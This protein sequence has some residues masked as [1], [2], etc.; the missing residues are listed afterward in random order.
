[1]LFSMLRLSGVLLC[2]IAAGGC[3]SDNSNTSSDSTNAPDAPTMDA[4]SEIEARFVSSTATMANGSGEILVDTKTGLTWINGGALDSRGDGCVSPANA[5]P[6]ELAQVNDR[7]VA[8]QYAGFDDWRAP[9]AAELSDLIKSADAD[10]SVSLKY[11]NPACPALVASDGFVRTENDNPSAASVQPGAATGDIFAAA[12][13]STIVVLADLGLP[14]GVRCVRSGT[15]TEPKVSTGSTRF[16]ALMG[17]SGGQT[18]VDSQTAL[19]WINDSQLDSNGDGCVSPANVG[20]T[21]PAEAESRCDNQN[22][23]G[24]SDWRAPTAAELT[25]L[26]TAA[27]ADGVKLNYLNPMC[28]ALVGSDGIVRTENANSAAE[29]AFPD[30]TTGAVLA[31]TVSGLNG[32]NAGVRCVRARN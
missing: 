21:E 16:S 9:S 2:V 1:M 4:G 8:Q 11:L 22:F 19:E 29:S 20:A 18:L 7:C 5:G 26:M 15:E 3:S 17:T 32:I 14:A 31:T 27:E 25:E 6:T 23:A 10:A 13:G 12:D 30:A 24:H 28:P